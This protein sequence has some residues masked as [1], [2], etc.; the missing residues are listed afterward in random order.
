MIIFEG[1][2]DIPEP[3]V[4]RPFQGITSGA[5]QAVH[6]HRR[7]KCRKLLQEP[8]ALQSELER[9]RRGTRAKWLKEQLVAVNVMANVTRVLVERTMRSASHAK[10]GRH[11]NIRT[12]EATRTA[13]RMWCISSVH[14]YERA[15]DKLIGNDLCKSAQRE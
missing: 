1:V 10:Q 7:G 4:Y 5:R 15:N 6:I 14:T 12:P 2:D 9:I 13:V 11:V 3:D 8:R